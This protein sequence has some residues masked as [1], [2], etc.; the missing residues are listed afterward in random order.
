MVTFSHLQ[1]GTSAQAWRDCGIE[2]LEP[3]PLDQVFESA[4]RLLVL[5]AHP[6]DETLG[7]SGLMQEALRRNITVEVL[8]C[9]DGE[10]SH[11][12]SSTYSAQQLARLRAGEVSQA[13]MQLGRDSGN[14]PGITVR[15]LGLPDGQL[16]E[17]RAELHEALLDRAQEAPCVLASTYRADA[18]TDHD[19]LG[20]VAAGIAQQL[21]L[22]HLEFPIWYWHWASPLEDGRWWHWNRLELDS[23]ALDAKRK[24]L[25]AHQ[26]QTQP[27]SDQPGDE[28]MLSAEV[29]EHFLQ[30]REIFRLTRSGEKDTAM[31][32]SV[33]E[34]L[35]L[36]QPDPWNYRD[37]GYEERKRGILLSSLPRK[38][39]GTVLE[40]GC[41][42]GIQ[43]SALA[44]RCTSLVAIDS[45]RTAL[46]QAQRETAHFDHVRLEQ[47]LLPGQWPELAH[48]T[49][50]LVVISEIGYFLAA[51]ELEELLGL[52][53]SVLAP[54][55]ELLLC[56][57][58]HPI[59]GWPL[60]GQ[61]VHRI[62]HRRRWDRLVM[63]EER[64]FLLEIL[65]KPGQLDG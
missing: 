61:S 33:F 22:F 57:W 26:S 10:A 30:S 25:S 11:P 52:C 13:M 46:E 32:S 47:R 9:T 51:D 58:L 3:L 7:A 24:A 20:L 5:A 60:D 39:Y 40:L 54:G 64:D 21:S 63:H 49:V 4:Q 2:D 29:M 18:H 35:Y 56:H 50:D 17:H 44:E 1:Q 16:A 6:D 34:D 38:H 8:L 45:S 62:A 65:R 55:G 37:S 43:T 53:E 42:I 59:E 36:D 31:T 12:D 14:G 19:V 27:L 41:S 28:A 48:G 15:R 23:A